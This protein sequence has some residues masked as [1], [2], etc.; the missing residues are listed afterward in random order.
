MKIVFFGSSDFAIPILKALKDKEDIRLLV[1]QPDRRKGRSLKLDST[2][3]KKVSDSLG[4]KSFQ[5]ADVNSEDSIDYLK[6]FNADI[7]V[8]VSF[9]QILSKGVLGLPRKL[10]LNVHSSLLPKY[11]GAAPINWTLANGERET[12]ISII[13]MNEKM[14]AGD[15]ILQKTLPIDSDEDAIRLSERLSLEGALALSESIDLI[16]KGKAVFTKQS[17]AEVTYA[18]K[19]KKEDGIIAWDSSAHEIYN[20]IRAFVPWPGCF[21]Y[22]DKKTVKIWKAKALDISVASKP[23]TV[24]E[25]GTD[26]I[27]VAAGKGVLGIEELQLEG[28]RRMKAGEF[29]RGHKFSAGDIFYCRN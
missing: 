6:G 1:T 25:L 19:L 26:K 21:T 23:G 18:P 14:D 4:L 5:P 17:E 8:V 16:D 9:G 7:F 15:I 12:G 11:R 20:R 3:V 10:V 2:P 13:K 22:W 27:L 29:T 24:L 28:R